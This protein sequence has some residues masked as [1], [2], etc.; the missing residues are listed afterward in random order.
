MLRVWVPTVVGL[1]LIVATMRDVM[2][3]LFH[4]E[5]AG[6]LSRGVTHAVWR[7]TRGAARLHRPLIQQGG[8]AIL[9]AVALVWAA[10]LVVGW[11]LVI[12]PRLPHSFNPDPGLPPAAARGFA[13]AVYVSMAS[14]TTLSAG[15]LGPV[16]DGMRW[17]VTLESYVGLVLFTAWITWVLG[18]YPMLAERRAFAHRVALYRRADVRPGEAAREW[19]PE[20]HAAALRELEGDVLRVMAHLRQSRVTYYFQSGELELMLA[21]QLPW[22][23]E[24]ARRAK[25]G[26]SGAAVRHHG[27]MLDLSVRDLLSHIGEQFL[28]LDDAP[29]ERIVRAM[30]EDHMLGERGRPSARRDRGGD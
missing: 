15:D 4:P 11:A 30:T 20:A 21:E 6:S 2:H 28:D 25:E 17:A 12:W 7:A 27:E 10:L 19:P 22:V 1:L 24:F 5:R 9:V 18:I 13:T 29:P 23:L 8:P 16:T 14:M 26:G 3:E